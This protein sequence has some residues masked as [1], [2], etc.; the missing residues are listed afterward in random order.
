[1]AFIGSLATDVGTDFSYE[2]TSNRLYILNNR[3]DVNT[4]KENLRQALGSQPTRN[5]E[6]LT[7][8]KKYVLRYDQLKRLDINGR[9][10]MII[11][12]T[13]ESKF[14]ELHNSHVSS[15]SYAKSNPKKWF[16]LKYLV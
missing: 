6:M 2:S 16:Q 5:E 9:L 13:K 4:C 14:N 1:M 8:F 10:S 12:L 15:R 3:K 7:E 11:S